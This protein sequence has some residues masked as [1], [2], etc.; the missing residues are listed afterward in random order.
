MNSEEV[1]Q[2]ATEVGFDACGI[3]SAEP[4]T[5]DFARWKEW[6][7]QGY[8]ATMHYMERRVNP[9]DILENARSV[10]V[11]LLNYYPKVTQKEG[12]PRIARYA[13]SRDY[14]Y[15]MWERLRLLAEKTGLKE[16][17]MACDT[18]PVFD[19]ALAVRAG[20]GW[21]GRNNM[22][23]NPKFG[24]YTFIGELLTTLPLIPDSPTENHCGRCRR[25][26]DACPTGALTE[27]CLDANRCLSFRTIEDK[28]PLTTEEAKHNWVFGCDTCQMACPWNK[29]FAH[30]HEHKEFAPTS[31]EMDITTLSNSALRKAQSPF[32]RSNI[33]KLKE[34][35]KLCI[36]NRQSS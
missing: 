30:P 21:I 24:S 1:K 5:D 28:K 33:T 27:R 31:L 18:M 13:Y 26:L 10:I 22:L 11:C 35:H 17:A 34:N 12:E 9:T 20:L 19:R 14:H 3:A 2:R 4:F 23:V 25:C 16:Y 15:V 29:R 36:S 6:L 32:C 8:N 7:R